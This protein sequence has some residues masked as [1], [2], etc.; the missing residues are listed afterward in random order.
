MWRYRHLVFG[1]ACLTY[2]V[3][4]FLLFPVFRINILIP[5]IIIVA[6]SAWYYGTTAALALILLSIPYHAYVMSHVHGDILLIYQAKAFGACIQIVAA[7]LVGKLKFMYDQ[8]KQL[9]QELDATVIERTRELKER[10]KQLVD[11]DEKVRIELGQD[12]H[13]GLGQYLTG[14]L[15][16]SSSLEAELHDTQSTDVARATNLV[17]SAQKNL[18]LARK[19]SRTLFPVRMS[20]IGLKPA[21]FELTSYF[22]ETN[23]IQFNVQIDPR[24]HRL[25]TPAKIHIYRIVYGGI[26]ISLHHENPGDILI[27]LSFETNSGILIIESNGNGGHATSIDDEVQ[28]INYRVQQING[29][30]KVE[31]TREGKTRIE[32][33]MPYRKISQAGLNV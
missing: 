5:S 32:C 1:L 4:S 30:L 6:L 19:V 16:Y 15:L 23:G 24:E 21:I 7:L 33:T 12:I 25:T 27:S 31:R 14:L 8:I 28:L 26:M 22:S 2:V 29:R 18:H 20:E 17:E 11:R 3:F 13:D 9:N 10:T